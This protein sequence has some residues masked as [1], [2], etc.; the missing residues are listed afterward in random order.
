MSDN[1]GAGTWEEAVLWL[2][3]QPDRQGLVRAAYYDDP[4]V[5]AAE[6]YLASEE[7]AAIRLL[8]GSSSGEALD[9]GAGRGIASYALAR[10]GFSVTALEP[11]SSAIVG[12]GAIRALA[13]HDNLPIRVVEDFGEQLPFE[14][15]HFHVAFARAALHHT[16][17]L[18]AACREI[19]RVL[20]PGG[21]FVAVREHVIS[22][23]EDLPTFLAAHPLH[24]LYGGEN[25]FLLKEY[26][27]A[28]EEAGFRVRT[29][30]RPFDSPINYAPHT[31]ATLRAEL[32]R[33][34]G[35]VPGASALLTRALSSDTRITTLLG[36]A[37]WLDWR[38]GRHYSFVCDQPV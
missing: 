33:R 6:R 18:R 35:R 10:D 25:A 3:K 24:H 32:A 31:K 26:V 27:G 13:D 23:R 11:D 20:R 30:L 29:V 16:K 38:P 22:K 2:R 34:V 5:D 7:W 37:S 4:L 28:L 14:A 15:S 17:N 19:F 8:L 12:A 21:R 9:V 1:V 36:V